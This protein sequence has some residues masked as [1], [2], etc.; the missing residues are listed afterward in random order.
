MGGRMER[1]ESLLTEEISQVLLKDLSG[2]D[3]GLA[4]VTG[5]K[6]ARDLSQATVYVSV[7]GDE[8]RR[9]QTIES[10]QRSAGYIKGLLGKRLHLK[11]IPRLQFVD[12]PSL[13]QADRIARLLKDG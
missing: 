6:I 9:Q 4:T 12:D 2:S 5:V 1:L 11:R 8:A 7:L 3:L 13:R 10:L